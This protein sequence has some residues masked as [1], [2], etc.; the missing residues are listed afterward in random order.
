MKIQHTHV[1]QELGSSQQV[2]KASTSSSAAGSFASLL[3]TYSPKAAS[4]AIYSPAKTATAPS[5]TPSTPPTPPPPFTASFISGATVSAPDGSAT[6]LN[7]VELATPATAQEV[8]ALLGGTVVQ[9]SMSGGYTQS[10]ATAEISVPGSANEI[11]AGL[12]ANLFANYGTAAGS[13]AWQIIDADLG[14]G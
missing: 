11:N 10:A 3:S 4:G 13:Q 8:A 2:S 6:S 12:A 1:S 7:P 14:K 9:D 5:T